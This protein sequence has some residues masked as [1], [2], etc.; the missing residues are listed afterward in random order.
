MAVSFL[1]EGLL[2]L[3]RDQPDVIADLLTRCL[4]VRVPRFTEARLTEAVLNEIIPVE[5]Y[6]DAVVLLTV[7]HKPVLGVIVEAQ[8]RKDRRKPYTWPLYAMAARARH[9][10]PFVVVVLTTKP[11]VARWAS[12]PIH[13]GNGTIFQFHVIGPAGIPKLTNAERAARDPQLAVLSVMAHGR[14]NTTTARQIALAAIAAVS[15]LRDQQQR[16]LYSERRSP[17]PC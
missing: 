15:T 16:E 17:D 12:R 9:E 14:A 1:H 5:H 3:I 10:C 4:D 11:L 13:V 6:A 2:E 8:L 7:K